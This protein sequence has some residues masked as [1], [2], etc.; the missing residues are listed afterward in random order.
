M[1][2]RCLRMFQL[3]PISGVGGVFWIPLIYFWGRAP[4]L[5]WIIFTGM[6]FTLG[7]ALV[8]TF[9]GYYGLRALQGFTL[10]GGQSIGL[11]FIKDM[12]FFHQ[13]ARKIGIWTTIF[14]AC[15]YVG[16]MFGY[17]IVAKT[18]NWRIIF[19]M[20]FALCWMVLIAILLFAD[21][22]YYRRD[23][24]RELQPKRGNRMMRLLGIWQI[25]VHRG[26]FMSVWNSYKRMALL[27]VK[28][29]IIPLLIY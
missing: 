3:T 29:V 17:F 2:F 21:E 5:F 1:T 7:C 28:P 13:Q 25:R 12:F 23:I 15:P 9:D 18:D 26:Y 10:A 6:L 14:L 24:P 22:T 4:V 19:W 16:P 11:A 20:T 27:F 8:E